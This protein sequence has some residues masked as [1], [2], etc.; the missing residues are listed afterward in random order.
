MND[1]F[2]LKGIEMALEKRMETL[3]ALSLNVVGSTSG[4]LRLDL[5]SHGFLIGW[6]Q[7]HIK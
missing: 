5:R 4:L 2:P 3:F 6:M 1:N 7:F